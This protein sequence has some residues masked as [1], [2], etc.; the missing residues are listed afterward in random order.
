LTRIRTTTKKKHNKWRRKKGE[1]KRRK[2]R[3][4]PDVIT[5]EKMNFSNFENCV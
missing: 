4:H 1:K 3:L 2:K 5:Q